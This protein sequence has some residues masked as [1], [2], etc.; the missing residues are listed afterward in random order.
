MINKIKDKINQII[1]EGMVE[2]IIISD[3]RQLLNEPDMRV[4]GLFGD[5]MEE[6]IAELAHALIYLDELNK[7]SE[8][9]AQKPVDFYL[10]TYGGSADDM[11]ALYDIMRNVR[12]DTEI[13]TIG[14]GKV[15]SAGVLL[16]AA[17]TKG[18]RCIGKNCRVMIHSVMG[19]NHGSLHNMMNEMEAIEQ[20]QQMYIDC[21]VDETKMTKNQIKKMLERKVNVYLS[22][23]EA[24]ELG[25]ADIII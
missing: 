20:L 8:E 3:P 9:S 5:V 13:R 1:G 25:I 21:L 11:F 12:S 18:K 17:G 24:V 19:G 22:A 2:K 14:L 4:I 10:S 23:E 6:K 16:L 7:L 15:M